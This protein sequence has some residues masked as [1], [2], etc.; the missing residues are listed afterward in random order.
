MKNAAAASRIRSIPTSLG[1]SKDSVCVKD[2]SLHA[3]VPPLVRPSRRLF[4][5]KQLLRR[6]RI[7]LPCRVNGP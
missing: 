3:K 1:N 6:R 5:R 4:G 2:P 7:N